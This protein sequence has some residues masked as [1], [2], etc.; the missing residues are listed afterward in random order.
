MTELLCCVYG[1]INVLLIN[2][3]LGLGIF[4]LDSKTR[5]RTDQKIPTRNRTE[6]KIYKYFLGLNFFYPKEPEPKGT[7]PNRPGP[8]K[9]RPE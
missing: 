2:L 1:L 7:D 5:T 4:N 3:F 6:P 9:N 8:E